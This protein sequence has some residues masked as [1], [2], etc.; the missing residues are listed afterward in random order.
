M[1][2]K[3]WK[4]RIQK[5]FLQLLVR[6]T[7]NKRIIDY[8]YL[9]YHNQILNYLENKYSTFIHSFVPRHHSSYNSKSENVWILWYQGVEQAPILVKECI[10][11]IKKYSQRNVIIVTQENYKCYTDIAPHVID[12]FENGKISMTHFSDIIRMSILKNH[13]GIWM[14]STIFLSSY[15]PENI[16]ANKFFTLKSS[17][18]NNI[19]V[20]NKRWTTFFIG[21]VEGYPLFDFV[22]K[23]YDE[24]WKSEDRIIDYLL[25]DYIIAI[26]YKN[27]IGGFKEDIDRLRFNNEGNYDLIRNINKAVN[28]NLLE[29]VFGQET[30]VFK[31]SYKRKIK[32]EK[33]NKTLGSM[34]LDGSLLNWLDQNHTFRFLK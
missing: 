32:I 6:I 9:S 24:Y 13:G 16:L 4:F 22:Q 28:D 1:K 10:K 27:N 18:K 8:F 5:L 17:Q 26:A 14:D 3:Y 12:K 2:N 15:V 33:Y 21:G 7:S 29:A 34:L 30:Y 19:N 25:F 20:A 11:S 23:F 31:L